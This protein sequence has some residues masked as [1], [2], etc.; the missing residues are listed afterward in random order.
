MSFPS[1]AWECVLPSS[2]W[3]LPIGGEPKNRELNQKSAKQSFAPEH[4]QAELG[5]DERSPPTLSFPS[6][7]W[8]CVLPSSAWRLPIGGEPKNRELNQ[9]S[10]KQSF[11]PEH[12]Q[13]ELGNDGGG[14]RRGW[15]DGVGGN[16][17]KT[18]PPHSHSS[19]PTNP[20][21][22][23]YSRALEYRQCSG[24]STY[25]RFTGFIWT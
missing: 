17:Q 21:S 3:R 14:G 10:A 23:A 18:P 6:S 15:N 2:A 16:R 24:R 20:S 11:A 22:P 25:P 5:N 8:E 4:S 1:S 13:A 9:K 19:T 7:A 12:S